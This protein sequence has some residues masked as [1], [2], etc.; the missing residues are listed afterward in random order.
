MTYHELTW[1][2]HESCSLH[3]SHGSSE[4]NI[5]PFSYHTPKPF[6]GSSRASEH[7][8]SGH[9]FEYTSKSCGGIN[10]GDSN[11]LCPGTSGHS[12]TA[13]SELHQ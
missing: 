5:S 12:E 11:Q 6:A 1:I 10:V 9:A 3:G 7:G 4:A 2:P 13:P 8:G